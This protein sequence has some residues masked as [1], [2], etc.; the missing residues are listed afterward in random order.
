[1]ALNFP[2]N[3]RINTPVPSIT[4]DPPASEVRVVP[5]KGPPGPVG[6]QGPEGPQGP[7]GD[8][9][10]LGF[11]WTQSSPAETLLI[12]HQFFFK[13]AGIL[14]IESDGGVLEYDTVSYPQT[15]YIEL[16]FGVP[17]AGQ[18]YLS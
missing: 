12:N 8:A 7:A 1:M 2:G 5:T 3:V 6:P 18:V 11:V 13:P 9:T 10:G 17:F 15:G 16:T 4:M 14:C